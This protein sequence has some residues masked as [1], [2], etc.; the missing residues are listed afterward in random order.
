MHIEPDSKN[1]RNPGNHRT[2]KTL[3]NPQSH[4][5]AAWIADIAGHQMQKQ[6]SKGRACPPG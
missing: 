5:V 4:P 6:N 3:N 2:Q 1:G